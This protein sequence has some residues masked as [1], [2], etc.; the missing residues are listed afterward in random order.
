[1]GEGGAQGCGP[2]W[3]SE[4]VAAKDSER[5]ESRGVLGDAYTVTLNPRTLDGRI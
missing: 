5:D 2:R 4:C 1:V 3:R